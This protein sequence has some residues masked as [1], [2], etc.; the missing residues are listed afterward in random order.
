VFSLP[1]VRAVISDRPGCRSR[2]RP[3]ASPDVGKMWAR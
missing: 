2:S 3:V 1:P